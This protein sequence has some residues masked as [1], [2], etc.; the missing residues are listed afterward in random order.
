[1]T[2][3]WLLVPSW[4]KRAAAWT[5]AGTVAVLGIFMAGKRDARQAAKKQE[6]EAN[7]K[8]RKKIDAAPVTDDPDV[9]RE[10]L[11]KLS[12]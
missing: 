3:L 7:V 10:R 6:L 8:T 11:R 1:M 9:A 5:V 2:W 4:L 12:K